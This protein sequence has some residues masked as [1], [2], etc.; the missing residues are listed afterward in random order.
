MNILRYTTKHL[1]DENTPKAI[2]SLF[3]FTGWKFSIFF[4]ICQFIFLKDWTCLAKKKNF[5]LKIFYENFDMVWLHYI[6]KFFNHDNLKLLSNFMTELLIL[7][8]F[9]TERALEAL[10]SQIKLLLRNSLYFANH[11]FTNY[12]LELKLFFKLANFQLVL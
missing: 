6:L 8:F 12:S 10:K 11:F 1:N 7:V 9:T 3:A 4:V 2:K 5:V